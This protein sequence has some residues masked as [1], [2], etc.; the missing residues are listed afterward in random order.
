MV[1]P[2]PPSSNSNTPTSATTPQV[3]ILDLCRI[4]NIKIWEIF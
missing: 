2:T 1:A 3:K 4:S